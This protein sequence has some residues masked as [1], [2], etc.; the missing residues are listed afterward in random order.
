MFIQKPNIVLKFL[1]L[2]CIFGEYM[3]I[4]CIS[5][6][7]ETEIPLSL[8]MSSASRNAILERYRFFE[9]TR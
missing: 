5:S 3:G 4:G 9:E 6:V 8:D 7:Y 2:S 1:P